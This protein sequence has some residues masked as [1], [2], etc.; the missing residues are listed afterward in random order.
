MSEPTPLETLNLAIEL[1]LREPDQLHPG[2]FITGWA[3]G[4]STSRVQAE[5]DTALP[6]VT[7]STYSLGP[8]TSIIPTRDTCWPPD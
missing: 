8:Q 4:V 7:G 3:L 2:A 1:F 6:M 5:D